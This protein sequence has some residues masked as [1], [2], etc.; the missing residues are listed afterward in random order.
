MGL[1]QWKA[2]GRTIFD[3]NLNDTERARIQKSLLKYSEI[4]TKTMVKIFKHLLDL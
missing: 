1:K 3:E 4:D 2:G